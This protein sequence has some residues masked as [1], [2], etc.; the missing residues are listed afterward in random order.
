MDIEEDKKQLGGYLN[1]FH[2]VNSEIDL[3]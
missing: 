3:N 1:K 2:S